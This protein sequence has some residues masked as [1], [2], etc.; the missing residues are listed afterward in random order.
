MLQAYLFFQLKSKVPVFVYKCR[1]GFLFLVDKNSNKAFAHC[2]FPPLHGRQGKGH[3][4]GSVHGPRQA[5]R[6]ARGV[7]GTSDGSC[8]QLLQQVVRSNYQGGE[9]P[10]EA[11]PPCVGNMWSA[12]GRLSVHEGRLTRVSVSK[13]P[14]GRSNEPQRGGRHRTWGPWRLKCG[15]LYQQIPNPIN[16]SIIMDTRKW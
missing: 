8:Q 16:L 9:T 14:A 7:E 11:F 2:Y 12:D 5:G 6:K 3:E 1:E 10:A 15:G 4:A 13:R